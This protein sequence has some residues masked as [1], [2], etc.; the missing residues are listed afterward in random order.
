M[1]VTQLSQR[2][3]R[4]PPYTAV[5][6]QDETKGSTGILG[7]QGVALSWSRVEARAGG[8][9]VGIWEQGVWPGKE[10]KGGRS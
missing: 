10:P 5:R 3:E 9:C 1:C 2:P 6:M 4:N 7:A 8:P